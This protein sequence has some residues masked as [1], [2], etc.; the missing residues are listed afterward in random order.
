MI[1]E[2]KEKCK[3]LKLRAFYENLEQT[4]ETASKR[5]WSILETVEHLMQLELDLRRKNRIER[6]FRQSG[7]YEKPTVD[8]FDF[9]HHSSRKRQKTDC[10]PK[11][12]EGGPAVQG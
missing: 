12:P 10:I 8:Q 3:L 4:L 7:L 1:E 5:N 11:K 6:C 2:V 9:D